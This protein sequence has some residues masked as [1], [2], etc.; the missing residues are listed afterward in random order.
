MRKPKW[1]TL[2]WRSPPSL[3]KE[4]FQQL[5]AKRDLNNVFGERFIDQLEHRRDLLENKRWRLTVWQIPIFLFLA[6]SLLNMDT[7]IILFGISVKSLSHI[8]EVLLIIS[9]SLAIWAWT[10]DTPI[11]FIQE[12]MGACINKLSN[13]DDDLRDFLK[14]RYGLAGW[15]L[16]VFDKNL[17]PTLMYGIIAIM[18]LLAI[19]IIAIMIVAIL[20]SIQIASLYEINNY[21]N[22]SHGVSIFVISY[23]GLVDFFVLSAAI[24]TTVKIPYS[25]YEDLN[26]L[27]R[28]KKRNPDAHQKII[29]DMV[30]EYLKRKR[31]VRMFTRPKLRRINVDTQ[32]NLSK[33]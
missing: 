15:S 17:K 25:T 27:V 9:S 14:I 26:M 32:E 6:F 22:F 28:L 21:P 19:V 24:L 8:R 11:R 12:M 16:K 18:M 20:L 10:I 5:L 2:R 23:V 31:I 33:P 3:R 4:R 29:N 1:T 13:N 30:N 7:S